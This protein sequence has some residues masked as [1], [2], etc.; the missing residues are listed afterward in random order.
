MFVKV[1][2][3]VISLACEHLETNISQSLSLPGW[4]DG[5]CGNRSNTWPTHCLLHKY[6]KLDFERNVPGVP[7]GAK[8]R[9]AKPLSRRAGS[10][11]CQELYSCKNVHFVF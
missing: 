3:N 5:S 8:L 4:A 11:A 6:L 2:L 1:W 10:L 7:Q 9:C